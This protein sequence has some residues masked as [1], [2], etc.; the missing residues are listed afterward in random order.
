MPLVNLQMGVLVRAQGNAQAP[1]NYPRETVTPGLSGVIGGRM[2]ICLPDYL[3]HSLNSRLVLQSDT[4]PAHSLQF[5]LLCTPSTIPEGMWTSNIIW[6]GWNEYGKVVM[7][8]YVVPS[9]ISAS[10]EGTVVDNPNLQITPILNN[11]SMDMIWH[12]NRIHLLFLEF[13][14][15]QIK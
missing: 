3:W 10:T 5:F 9:G 12:W 11:R 6:V 14:E 8:C 4:L 7:K 13:T 2:V 15:F 1:L